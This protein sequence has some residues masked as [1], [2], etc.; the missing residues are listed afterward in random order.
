[1][2]KMGAEMGAKDYV[3]AMETG[4]NALIEDPAPLRSDRELALAA[5]DGLSGA[6]GAY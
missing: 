1:M 5:L 6:P 2:L 4:L 3:D